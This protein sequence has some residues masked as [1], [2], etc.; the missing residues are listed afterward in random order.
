MRKLRVC[1]YMT[2]LVS[3][4]QPLK[5]VLSYSSLNQNLPMSASLILAGLIPIQE[6]PKEWSTRNYSNQDKARIVNHLWCDQVNTSTTIGPANYSP[7]VPQ[8]TWRGSFASESRDTQS[9][10]GSSGTVK[11]SEHVSVSRK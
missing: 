11:E 9:E 4:A 7:E 8:D 2:V 3:E 1:L 6:A 10:T 5:D